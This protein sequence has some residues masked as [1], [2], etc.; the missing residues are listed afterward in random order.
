MS[1]F[2]V[3]RMNG[4]REKTDGDKTVSGFLQ[5]LFGFVWLASLASAFGVV[6]STFMTRESVRELEQ[7][8]SV[9][10]ELKVV[11]GQYQLERSSLGAYARVESIAKSDLSMSLPSAVDTVLVV[12]E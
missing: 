12:R 11:S 5:C 8:R 6:Y 10:V 7:L 3:N 2:A 1:A 4:H 9:A